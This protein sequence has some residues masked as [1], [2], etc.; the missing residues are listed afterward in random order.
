MSVESLLS[1]A[2]KEKTTGT[3]K[4]CRVL[5]TT[6]AKRIMEQSDMNPAHG[7]GSWSKAT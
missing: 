7:E 4:P 5:G 6:N 2:N 1:K 3:A